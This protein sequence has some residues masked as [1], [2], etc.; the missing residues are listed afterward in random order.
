MASGK[1]KTRG[2]QPAPLSSET[3]NEDLWSCL[4]G[5]KNPWM[6]LKSKTYKTGEMEEVI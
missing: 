4:A 1:A 2:D 5:S 3:S 6:S